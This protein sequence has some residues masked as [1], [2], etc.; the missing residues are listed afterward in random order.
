VFTDIEGPVD[1]GAIV[2]YARDKLTRRLDIVTDAR[3]EVPPVEELVAI[4]GA[5][6]G[7]AD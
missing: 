6:P 5:D 4:E 2:E 7:A 1:H 3:C